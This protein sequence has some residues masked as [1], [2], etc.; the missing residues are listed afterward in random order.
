M[1]G[2]VKWFRK[3]IPSQKEK[4]KGEYVWGEM[5]TEI[6]SIIK[7]FILWTCRLWSRTGRTSPPCLLW[8]DW[9]CVDS[10]Y[11]AKKEVLPES[12]ALQHHTFSLPFGGL[13]IHRENRKFLTDGY[14]PWSG[15]R[16]KCN[17]EHSPVDP[18]MKMQIL[19][20]QVL[21]QKKSCQFICNVKQKFSSESLKLFIDQV[22]K[23]TYV[24]HP[25][26][27]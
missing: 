22:I 10:E 26:T 9:L 2:I 6:R 18:H 21:A 19:H 20:Q 7:P 17:N 1:D 27:N 25:S 16:S 12:H 8:E 23:Y 15:W 4:G 5:W 3:K 13:Q 14:P 11:Q 24:L